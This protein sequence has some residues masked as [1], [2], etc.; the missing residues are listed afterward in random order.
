MANQNLTQVIGTGVLTIDDT[1]L[2]SSNSL[3]DLIK[4]PS[5]ASDI[6][7][8]NTKFLKYICDLTGADFFEL[9]SQ[10]LT[11]FLDKSYNYKLTI[12]YNGFKF[13]I[14]QMLNCQNSNEDASLE[15][16]L[17]RIDELKKTKDEIEFKEKFPYFYGFYK[18][19]KDESLQQQTFKMEYMLS[20]NNP[21]QLKKLMKRYNV[22][23]VKELD[24]YYNL[25]KVYS[26]FD[27]FKNNSV[28]FFSKLITKKDEILNW[29]VENPVELKLSEED[30]KKV[31]LFV[32]W[33]H[34]GTMSI[35]SDHDN[36]YA[37]QTELFVLERLLKQYQE[38]YPNDKT[39]ILVKASMNFN[40]VND[41]SKISMEY[42]IAKALEDF[43]K[44]SSKYTYLK[45][46]AIVPEIDK[47]LSL[48]ENIK[49]MEKY[50]SSLV[51]ETINEDIENGAKDAT[52][53]VNKKIEELER[54]IQ[55]TN[56]SL[57]DRKE[58][59]LILKKIRMVVDDIKPKAIQ[60]GTGKVFRNYYVYYYSNGMV[61]VDRIDGYGALYIMPV[62][63]YNIA[64][65][66]DNLTEVQQLPGVERVSHKS[67]DWLDK[68]ENYIKN[69][70]EGLTEI[71]IEKSSEVA[72]TKFPYTIEKLEEL[73]KAFAEEGNEQGVNEAEKRIRKIEK[74]KKIDAEIKENRDEKPTEDEDED[75]KIRKANSEDD[76]ELIEMADS[77]KLDAEIYDYAIKKHGA[78]GRKKWVRAKTK[79]RAKQEDG[80]ICC[81]LCRQA[82]H[83][84]PYM[85][86]SHHIILLAKG[87]IDNIYN[88]VCLC[89]GCHRKAHYELE[90]D[91]TETQN[92]LFEIVR[93]HLEEENPEYIEEFD[94]MYFKYTG[95]NYTPLEK[96][97]VKVL[98]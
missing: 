23:T 90:N 16:M 74:Y 82:T 55:S 72:T 75:I 88:T 4:S 96:A 15:A 67:K 58:K 31:L 40:S 30:M 21:S 85:F 39:K 87:G 93:K 45:R 78:A 89:P 32:I 28:T 68:A 10:F 20:R 56:I 94:K 47:G 41:R 71:D 14:E 18:R 86:D 29:A 76:K 81:E 97:N 95:E 62:H 42:T 43:E 52:E 37:A 36:K 79:E 83:I 92:I 19:S 53:D 22:K 77:G 70:T 1:L 2:L 25:L 11:I 69:G 91:Q 65:Y 46:D 5:A 35:N 57:E 17:D 44:I 80:H 73:E 27:L 13:L 60:T 51:G 66:K 38:K 63:I 50:I 48:S 33:T 6:S 49:N 98:E 34:M 12:S 64:R 7:N 61:A 54:D 9:P 3:L 59:A 26:N 24:E 84:S 8:Y